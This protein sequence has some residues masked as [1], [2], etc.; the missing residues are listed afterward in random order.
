MNHQERCKYSYTQLLH[1]IYKSH[2]EGFLSTW[3]KDKLK[4]YIMMQNPIIDQIICTNLDP[5]S[6]REVLV[7]LKE[8]LLEEDNTEFEVRKKL[9]YLS[10]KNTS[11]SDIETSPC[12]AFLLKVKKRRET[13]RNKQKFEKTESSIKEGNSQEHL[14]TLHEATK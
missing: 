2:K 10:D 11:A 1:E 3:E 12:D 8:V 13:K 9:N 4:S 14:I 6:A 5:I 7:R